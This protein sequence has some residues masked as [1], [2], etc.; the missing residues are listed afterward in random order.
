MLRTNLQTLNH[1]CRKVVRGST[2]G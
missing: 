1:A 2:H